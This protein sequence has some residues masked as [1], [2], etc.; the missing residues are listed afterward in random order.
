MSFASK[1]LAVGAIAAI[2]LAIPASP[3]AS[4]LASD[5]WHSFRGTS[6]ATSVADQA[7][8]TR[9]CPSLDAY[10]TMDA[11]G[12]KAMGKTIVFL[13]KQSAEATTDPAVKAFLDNVPPALMTGKKVQSKAAKAL[14]A[15]ECAAHGEALKTR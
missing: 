3:T 15:R 14:V 8:F 1:T 9:I 13:A 11:T 4:A 6:A 12:Q 2:A 10:F 7:T 5:A